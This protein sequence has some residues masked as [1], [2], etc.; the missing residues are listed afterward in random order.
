MK[1]GRVLIRGATGGAGRFL[2]RA[3]RG[4]VGFCRDFGAAPGRLVATFGEGRFLGAAGRF[5]NG[6]RAAGAFARRVGLRTRRFRLLAT[7]PLSMRQHGRIC[8]TN[9][10]DRSDM[11]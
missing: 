10:L 1:A 5:L 11:I 4:G 8:Q 3:V 7:V 2:G 9:R 6:R